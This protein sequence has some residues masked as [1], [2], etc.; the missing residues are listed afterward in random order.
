MAQFGN[1]TCCPFLP[2]LVPIIPHPR[3]K[4]NRI[5]ARLPHF[6]QFRY[7]PASPAEKRREFCR[8][9]KTAPQALARG[10]AISSITLRNLVFDQLHNGG[11]PQ[12]IRAQVNEVLRIL[13]GA[14]APGGLDFHLGADVGLEDCH[15]LPSGSAGGEPG[16]SYDLIRPR[17]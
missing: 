14:D 16:G 2:E 17:Q 12:T 4:S 3:P 1:D 7:I 15:I 8:N 5:F 10:A 9:A 6:L 13:E 11:G